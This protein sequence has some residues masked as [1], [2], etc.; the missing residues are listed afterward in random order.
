MTV[1]IALHNIYTAAPARPAGYLDDVLSKGTMKGPVLIMEEEVYQELQIKYGP[2]RRENTPPPIL[3]GRPGSL[4]SYVI[5][6]ITGKQSAG[7]QMCSARAKQMNKWGWIGCFKNRD[8]ILGWLCEEVEKMGYPVDK[9]VI[10]SLLKA[11]I[12]ETLKK[13][14]LTS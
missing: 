8:T 11:A 14:H 13:Q 5:Y 12:V 2:Y 1:N 6:S 7:C 9:H 3:S 4:L 10:L